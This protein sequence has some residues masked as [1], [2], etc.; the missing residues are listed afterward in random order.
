MTSSNL[1]RI[2]LFRKRRKPKSFHQITLWKMSRDHLQLFLSDNRLY[3]RIKVKGMLMSDIL[4]K[5]KENPHFQLINNTIK[6]Q[7]WIIDRWRGRKDLVLIELLFQVKIYMKKEDL[8]KWKK[9]KRANLLNIRK[10]V[11]HN[12]GH[13]LLLCLP[14]QGKKL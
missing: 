13:W 14:I 6:C 9:S 5:L 2:K 3:R 4:R 11:Y 10:E 8:L 1:C 12:K 7:P